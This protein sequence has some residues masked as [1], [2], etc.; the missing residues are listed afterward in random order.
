MFSIKNSKCIINLSY[1]YHLDCKDPCCVSLISE[2]TRIIKNRLLGTITKMKEQY[3]LH[4]EFM[5]TGS[6]PTDG[7]CNIYHATINGNNEEYGS[8]T[9]GIWILYKNGEMNPSVRSAVNENKDYTTDIDSI[10]LN[11]WIIINVSQTKIGT[12]YQYVVETNGK[13]LDTVKNTK[14]Q[15]FENVKIYISNPWSLAV[16]GYV[17]NVY[18]KGKLQLNTFDTLCV[19]LFPCIIT[20]TYT[21]KKLQ[22]ASDNE[23]KN[24]KQVLI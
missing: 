11:K 9:P 7:W 5:V 24:S 16:P 22:S 1:F 23:N 20:K 12:E 15:E 19:F 3:S 21:T 6:F 17:R 2:Q 18:L 14:P 8:R 4:V 10:Q 13:V